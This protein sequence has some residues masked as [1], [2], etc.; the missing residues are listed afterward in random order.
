M[1]RLTKAALLA[2]LVAVLWLLAAWLSRSMAHV[3]TDA[4]LVWLSSGITFAALLVAARWAWPAL[5]A[6]AGLAAL[7][8]AMAYHQ[9]GI[10]PALAFSGV[11]IASMSL[12]A[13]VATLGRH[14]PQAPRGA[15]LMLAGALLAS[16][17]WATLA[18][19]LWVWLRPDADIG[20][21]W[22]A[23]ALSTVVGL[24]LVSIAYS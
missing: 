5:L 20:F 9:L 14:D 7:I 11:E 16:L 17:L 10:G 24:L 6:G 19:A 23:R 18:A 15:A 12:G 4:T 8:W 21:E 22:R 1:Q 13:W 3:T 2:A